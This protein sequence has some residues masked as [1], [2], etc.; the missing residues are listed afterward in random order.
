MWSL[1][2]PLGRA[3]ASDTALRHGVQISFWSINGVSHFDSYLQEGCLPY[4]EQEREHG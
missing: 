1:S 2:P 4:F 3:A